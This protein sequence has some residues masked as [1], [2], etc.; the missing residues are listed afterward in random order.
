MLANKDSIAIS[1]AP[2]KHSNKQALLNKNRLQT[3]QRLTNLPILIIDYCTYN[4]EFTGVLKGEIQLLM[5]L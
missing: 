1:S 3:N 5:Y 2:L 4:E